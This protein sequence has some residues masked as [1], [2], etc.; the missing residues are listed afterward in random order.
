MKKEIVKA[1]TEATA[2]SFTCVECGY[3]LKTTGPSKLPTCFKCG[4]QDW[5]EAVSAV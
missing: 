3:V 2:G 1:G 5:E 4:C